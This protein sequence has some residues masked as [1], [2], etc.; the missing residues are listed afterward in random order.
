MKRYKDYMEN[1]QVSEET[2]ERFLKAM[3]EA[4]EDKQEAG[5]PD[6]AY[7]QLFLHRLIKPA[8]SLA[9]VLAA[10]ALFIAIIPRGGANMATAGEQW[11]QAEASHKTEAGLKP[12]A[13]AEENKENRPEI[14][15][16]IESAYFYAGM[17]EYNDAISFPA[18][19]SEKPL[20]TV[21]LSEEKKAFLER[22]I[23]R[24][25]LVEESAVLAGQETPIPTSGALR[26]E[27]ILYKGSWML[28]LWDKMSE[29]EVRLW[30]DFFKTEEER[31]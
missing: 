30:E 28:I 2:R 27:R 12:E 6:P 23:E 31:P 13:N 17:T 14:T 3:R 18:Y 4:A 8:A 16:E 25:V 7:K 11:T 29:E 10:A 26:P 24:E 15:A 20:K 19:S 22:E 21:S 1:I 5:T 9:A